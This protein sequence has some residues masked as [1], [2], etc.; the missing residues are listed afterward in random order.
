LLNASLVVCGYR[1]D[2]PLAFESC[3]PLKSSNGQILLKKLTVK[4]EKGK[5]KNLSVKENYQDAL[6]WLPQLLHV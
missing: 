2:F 1:K 4:K 3:V 6:N 5:G